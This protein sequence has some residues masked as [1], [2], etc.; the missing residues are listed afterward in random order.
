MRPVLLLE[1]NEVPWRLIDRALAQPALVATREFFSR[2]QTYTTMSDDEGELSPWITWPSLHRGINNT[3]HGIKNL[4]QDVA[5]FRG[6]PIW[7]EYRERDLLIGVCGSMQ[8][9]PPI[10]PGRGGFY[11]PDTFAHDAQTIPR[12]IEPLQA[13]NLDLVSKNGLVSRRLDIL[14]VRTLRALPLLARRISPKTLVRI[15]EQLVAERF[16]RSRKARRAIFQTLLFW[17]VFR[18]LYQPKTAPAFATF[19]TN[20]VA[21]VMHRFWN[22]VFP[23][24]F[25][26]ANSG[27]HLATMQFA[28]E[29]MDDILAQAL[30]WLEQ[31]PDLVVVFASSMGQAAVHRE[32]VGYVASITDLPALMRC[33][34]MPSGSYKPL[35]AM[36][37]QI[38][39]DVPNDEKRLR[40]RAALEGARTKSELPLFSVDEVAASLSITILTPKGADGTAGGF[41]RADG[42][43]HTW[44]Q[45]GVTL[46]DFADGT[47]YHIPE[48]VLAVV[49]RGL[50]ASV[51]R[52]KLPLTSVKAMLLALGEIS[53]PAAR[54]V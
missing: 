10:D 4:G 47:G 49:G 34:D 5:T 17:D 44:E 32:K 1:I 15:A 21:G 43:W 40:L 28:L 54:Q 18:S 29:V 52:Q 51:A 33:F 6:T 27:E 20:H 16:D 45:A 35:L 53:A 30:R 36:V 24:D 19:F 31:R 8:S 39:I 25:P 22:H 48:G 14:S 2:A 3:Q 13:L 26:E 50:D 46:N 42:L 37:P 7:Q 9:W 11:I 38:A 23:Q 41:S 12:D